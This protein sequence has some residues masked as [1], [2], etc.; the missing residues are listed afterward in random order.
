MRV[1]GSASCLAGALVDAAKS[2]IVLRLQVR[3]S[4]HTNSPSRAA[5]AAQSARMRLTVEVL[6]L[7]D[8]NAHGPYREQA[9]AVF[10]GR[11]FAM[12]VS[13]DDS[14]ESVWQQLEQRYKK[15]YLDAQQAAAFTIKKLQD[16]YDCDLDLGDTVSDIFDGETDPN[17]RVV[18]VV[19]SFVNRDFS[20]PPTSNLRPVKEQKRMRERQIESAH[21]RRRTAETEPRHEYVETKRD[22][23]LPST[24]THTPALAQA[25]NGFHNGSRAQSRTSR[26]HTRSSLVIVQDTQT[27]QAEFGPVIKEESPEL[28][29]P[30]P[31]LPPPPPARKSLSG[32]QSIPKIMSRSPPR[33]PARI[34]PP[35]PAAKRKDI[36]DLPSSEDERQELAAPARPRGRPARNATTVQEEVNML[37]NSRQRGR[38]SSD[39]TT[40]FLDTA[41]TPNK[42]LP[43]KKSNSDVQ[44][45][46]DRLLRQQQERKSRL[47]VKPGEQ[48]PEPEQAPEPQAIVDAV[49]ETMPEQE[50]EPEEAPQPEIEPEV[51]SETEQEPVAVLA[52]SSKPKSPSVRPTP[53]SRASAAASHS[54]A[55]FLSQSPAVEA[56]AGESSS[57][58][59]SE[60]SSSEDETEDEED[61]E[62]EE[63]PGAT[64]AED[65]PMPDAAV[66]VEAGQSQ[67]REALE[68]EEGEGEEE[69]DQEPDATLEE[70][71]PTPAQPPKS[72]EP[73]AVIHVPSSPPRL[74]GS[75]PSV[76]S[77]QLTASQLKPAVR[78][79]PIPLPSN[80]NRTP[81]RPNPAQRP[82]ARSTTFRTLREQLADAE[83]TPLTN[84]MKAYDPR[85]L[86]AKKLTAKTPIKPGMVNHLGVDEDSDD[87][88]SSSSSSSDS[89]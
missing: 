58:S 59:D 39:L 3:N 10:K 4:R 61:E 60:S 40:A 15:N 43:A 33:P 24:E 18:K 9:M 53:S 72:Q 35:H 5:M 28:G 32:S 8:E 67:R 62:M 7:A 66:E 51:A 13:V 56:A 82:S 77:S 22:Q 45:R 64:I 27:G 71:T 74:N 68:K 34:T 31:P 16:A 20:V 26:S 17:R 46:L 57:S 41:H 85:T 75:T 69:D 81:A 21:K 1:T 87:E 36:Y 50:P 6:P 2:L 70:P 11:R 76:K 52:R 19:P 23:A 25:P 89:D 84:G 83:T 37:N 48:E 78:H 47:S 29:L 55:R 30:P 44:A 80:L 88:S 79:T 49:P 38:Q 12:P 14:L 65:V 42:P 63:Q 54:P 86:S 73:P